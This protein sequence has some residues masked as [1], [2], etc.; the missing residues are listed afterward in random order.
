M[1]NYEFLELKNQLCFPLYLCS[2]E[3]IKKYTPILDEL[4]LT[5]TRYLVMMYFWERKESNL[6]SASEA[7]WIDSSTLTPIIKALEKS[8]YLT[9]K[10]SDKDER[11]LVI[12]L[13]EQGEKLKECALSVPVKVAA[14]LGIDAE[15]AKTLKTLLDKILLNLHSC[16]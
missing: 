1:E 11:N 5:Y 3:L 10:R 8:G 4:G 15:D 14:C 7:L 13:T 12:K 2:K 16:N 6:L 9:R